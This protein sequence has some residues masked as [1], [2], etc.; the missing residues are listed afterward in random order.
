MRTIHFLVLCCIFFFSLST[1]HCVEQLVE[2]DLIDTDL[3]QHLFELP[4]S[5]YHL[6]KFERHVAEELAQQDMGIRSMLEHAHEIEVAHGYQAENEQQQETENEEGADE[7][8][9]TE[10][11]LDAEADQEMED[12]FETEAD[13]SDAH[14]FD[15]PTSEFLEEELL[16]DPSSN[17]TSNSTGTSAPSAG[18]TL[19][20]PT[21]VKGTRSP[22]AAPRKPENKKR[23]KPCPPKR[24]HKKNQALLEMEAPVESVEFVKP[25]RK[26]HIHVNTKLHGGP[27]SENL[28]R[29]E[30]RFD[31]LHDKVMGRLN[32]LFSRIKR[33]PDTVTEKTATYHF[34]KNP[35]DQE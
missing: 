34:E 1:V 22:P 24:K 30:D 29:I 28:L 18:A 8:A 17:S 14:L 9:E 32:K 33:H 12:A 21:L 20:I 23:I 15:E 2:A 5:A 31:S 3:G 13:E 6:T 27:G 4:P 16:Q 26:V 11:D 25:A 10:T 35:I 19:T 7:A